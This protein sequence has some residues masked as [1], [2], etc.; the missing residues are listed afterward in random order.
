MSDTPLRRIY[1]DGHTVSQLTQLSGA[2]M[3]R[4]GQRITQ[5]D[6]L[7]AVVTVALGHHQEEV[8]ALLL[9]AVSEPETS[10]SIGKSRTAR[11]SITPGA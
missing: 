3:Q 6:V 10:L 9:G 7:S 4:T 8:V 1:A 2:V 5:A 11:S